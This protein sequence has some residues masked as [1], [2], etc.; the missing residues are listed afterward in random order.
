MPLQRKYRGKHLALGLIAQVGYPV[1]L[2]M[3]CTSP[4]YCHSPSTGMVPWGGCR[5]WVVSNV[6]ALRAA[7]VSVRL[8]TSPIAM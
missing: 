7:G 8:G 1:I 3:L 6:H 5:G 4:A 2:R